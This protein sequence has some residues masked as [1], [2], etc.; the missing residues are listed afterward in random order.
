MMVHPLSIY[1]HLIVESEMRQ[2]TNV[3]DSKATICFLHLNYTAWTINNIQG[4]P[5]LSLSKDLSLNTNL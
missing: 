4:L 1:Q 3:K 2:W 5:G